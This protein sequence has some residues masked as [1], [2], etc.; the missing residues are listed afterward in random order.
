[1][2]DTGHAI[3]PVS[4]RPEEVQVGVIGSCIV[5]KHRRLAASDR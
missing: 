1:M 3:E 2:V 4:I 5:T